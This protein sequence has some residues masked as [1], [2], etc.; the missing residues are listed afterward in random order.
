MLLY[1]GRASVAQHRRR[2]CEAKGLKSRP[3]QF[4]PR[5]F[6]PILEGS[7]LDFFFFFFFIFRLP[8]L[9]RPHLARRRGLSLPHP[10]PSLASAFCGIRQ[11]PPVRLP[12][13]F[14]AGFLSLCAVLSSLSA[15]SAL[16]HPHR[17]LS[18]A[19]KR[20]PNIAPL[21][22]AADPPSSS[23]VPVLPPCFSP[24]PPHF[25]SRFFTL[26]PAAPAR[27]GDLRPPAPRDLPQPQPQRAR[28]ACGRLAGAPLAGRRPR[29][30]Q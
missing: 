7:F 30:P 1:S 22:S 18:R 13:S 14:S 3:L 2:Q 29:A 26:L 24:E 16:G 23:P 15:A 17:R 9:L 20:T 21:L 8:A 11:L 25:P 10:A 19:P 6:D 12:R 28:A 5:S 4:S 27:R